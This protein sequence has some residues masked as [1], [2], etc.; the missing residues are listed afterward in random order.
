MLNRIIDFSLKNRLTILIS[1]LVL[2]LS[3]TYISSNMDIDVFPELTA[4]TVVIMTE[5]PGMAPQEVERLVTFPLETAVNGSTGIRRVRSSSS[6]G[7]SIVWVEFDWKTDIY[8]ARQTITER[9]IQVS[10][11]MPQG[12]NK[13]VLAPQS[14]LLGEMMIL[15]IESDSVSDMD[16]RTFAEWNLRPRLL[17]IP[18]VAQVTTI[19]GEFKEYQVLAD[20]YRMKHYQVSMNELEAVCRGLNSNS[21][22]GFINQYGNIY[23]VRG[24]ARTTNTDE[25][26]NA[27]IKTHNG[28]PVKIKD[29]ADV[30]TGPAP[31]IGEG[32][33]NAGNAVLLNIVKQPDIN[34]VNL[35]KEIRR[36]IEDIEANTSRDISI[37]SD[38]YN[39][40]DFINVSVRNVMRALIEGGIFVIII[41]FIFLLNTRTT[42]IS[43]LAIPLSL[44]FSIITLRL[45]DYTINT[46]SLGGMAIAIGSLVDDAIIDVENV[47]KHL[48][49]NVM[50]ERDRRKPVLRVIY[51]ASTEIRPSIFN[52]T[53]IIII[54]FIPFSSSKEWRAECLNHWVYHL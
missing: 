41:L 52:A 36:T 7:F 30:S 46:M 13:P 2:L 8:H 5:A 4:P 25:I 18:G 37:H 42:L 12:V 20:P 38:I 27:V 14:S 50:L 24:I 16:L 39:Q 21:S 9:I 45:L 29:V 47:Y 23:H 19:G 34:T 31:M 33:Y 53:L 6:M 54:T 11:E 1:A 40:A 17:S 48:R 15:A 28:L 10:A 51:E 44:L 22:G 32:S 43:L 26:G 49:S 3:G 35:T